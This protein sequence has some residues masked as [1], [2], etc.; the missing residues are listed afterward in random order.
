[1]KYSRIIAGTMTWG[2]WGKNLSTIDMVEMMQFCMEHGVTSFDNADIYGG[3]TTEADFG[4][5]FTQSGIKRESMQLISKCGI[6]HLSGGRN[7]KVGHYNYDKDYILWSVE[8]SLKQLQTE[9]LDVLLLHRPSPL[10]HPD[11]ISEAIQILK[12]QGK[13]KSFGVSNFTPSQVDLIAK[14][15]AVEVNQIE[16]SLTQHEAMF[17]GTL[18]QMMIKD[19]TPMAWSPLGTVFKDDTEQTRRIHKQLGELRDK[20]KA[21]E[22]QLL[23]AWILKHPSKIHPVVGTTTQSRILNAVKALEIDLELEDWFLMLV[24]GQGQAMP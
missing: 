17:D 10:M 13:I 21:T 4:K 23:L 18:D 8:T 6:Q 15:V 12:Q 7:N 1:M 22:G 20:Y 5:A 3:Y 24:A 11:E 2:R 14:N 19:M 16:F 9:Y